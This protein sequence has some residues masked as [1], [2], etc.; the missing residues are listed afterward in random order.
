LLCDHIL[1]LLDMKISFRRK[2]DFSYDGRLKIV[3]DYRAEKAEGQFKDI[4]WH[5]E[6]VDHLV[7][8]FKLVHGHSNNIWHFLDEFRNDFCDICIWWC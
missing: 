1:P 2:S 3:S 7:Q 6:A 4:V 5:K 8:Q